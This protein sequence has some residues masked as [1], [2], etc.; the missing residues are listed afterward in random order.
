MWRETSKSPSKNRSKVEVEEELDQTIKALEKEVVTLN[1]SHK[2]QLEI[3]TS[4]SLGTISLEISI[5]C[6]LRAKQLLISSCSNTSSSLRQRRGRSCQRGGSKHF[7]GQY[8]IFPF[9]QTWK[10]LPTSRLSHPSDSCQAPAY[11]RRLH[12]PWPCRT[13][14]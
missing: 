6:S 13:D 11:C 9:S 3:A 12:L 1:P 7:E 4:A 8:Y 2:N 5:W 14:M 10:Y